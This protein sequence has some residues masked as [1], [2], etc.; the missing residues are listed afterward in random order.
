MSYIA[1]TIADA[2]E[3]IRFLSAENARLR[4]NA[5]L[6]IIRELRRAAGTDGCLGYSPALDAAAD[7]LEERDNE[8]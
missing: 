8:Q 7:F 6:E 1:D 5:R 4:S 3:A 2:A